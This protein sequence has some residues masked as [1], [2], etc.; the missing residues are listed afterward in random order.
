[1][2]KLFLLVALTLCFNYAEAS[3]LGISESPQPLSQKPDPL[4]ARWFRVLEHGSLEQVEQLIG[5]IDINVT[6]LCGETALIFLASFGDENKIKRL[7]QVPGIDVNI[8]NIWGGSAL[9]RAVCNADENIVKLLLQIPIININ[10]KDIAGR[11]ALSMAAELGLENITKLLMQAIC[12][13][14]NVQDKNGRTALMHAIIKN[15]EH[16]VRLLLTVP[17]VEDNYFSTIN[18]NIKDNDNYTALMWAIESG[19]ENIVKILLD[20]PKINTPDTIFPALELYS[21][22]QENLYKYIISKLP[23]INA[24]GKHFGKNILIKASNMPYESLIKLILA[25][26]GI[27]INAQTND[28]WS[29]LMC[30]IYFR[31]N[32]IKLLLQFPGIDV[33]LRTNYDEAS[34]GLTALLVATEDGQEN[35]VKLL[36]A[37]PGINVNIQ[38]YYGDSALLQAAKS[39]NGNILNLLLEAP[40]INIHAQNMDGDTALDVIRKKHPALE[41]IIKNKIDQLTQKAFSAVKEEDT[42]TL[43]SLIEQI[44]TD[45]VDQQGNTLLHAACIKNSADIISLVLQ[46]APDPKDLIQTTNNRGLLAL[47]LLPP[48]SLLFTYFLDLAYSDPLYVPKVKAEETNKKRKEYAE[49][50]K[51]N[52]TSNSCA[53]CPNSNCQLRCSRCKIAYYC[54]PECQKMHWC[55]GHKDVC[56]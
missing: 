56:R 13:D 49:R 22:D 3:I 44:G 53:Y 5:I 20:H 6:N 54:S 16:I 46:A 51:P 48:T 27:N 55:N 32:Y 1:M 14:Y 7:L 35:V 31:Q 42:K 11:T 19:H 50:H 34:W 4:K 39:G 15:H 40:N 30:S 25:V 18:I 43:K 28:G 45:I 2:A 26:P 23:D 21:P 10:A 36:L 33:N 41:P 24:K 12:V 8:Q 29:P 37:V 52:E 9:M 17:I 38:N 47:E